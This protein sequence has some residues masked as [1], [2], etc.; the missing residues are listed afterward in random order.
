MINITYFWSFGVILDPF[1]LFGI[2]SDKI[3][4]AE[5][6]FVFSR[7][8]I[9]FCVKWSKRVQIVPIWP[10]II[11]NMLYWS[12]GIILDPLRPLWGIG[13]PAMFGHFWPH[14]G[15]FGPPLRT[16]LKDGNGK[17]CFKPTSYMSKDYACA[18]DSQHIGTW[19]NKE[20]GNMKAVCPTLWIAVARSHC[21]SVTTL[22]ALCA[23]FGFTIYGLNED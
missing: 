16:W 7:Q 13:N 18:T 20:Q 12:F 17:N 8:K 21:G 5:K 3:S 10:Q 15:H 6:H 1:G 4:L 22:Y 19:D 23:W 11:K 2:I 9:K 14:K